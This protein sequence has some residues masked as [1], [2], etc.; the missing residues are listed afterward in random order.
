METGTLARCPTHFPYCLL[1]GAAYASEGGTLSESPG[2]GVGNVWHV[3]YVVGG[4]PIGKTS[5]EDGMAEAPPPA[6]RCADWEVLGGTCYP[7]AVDGPGG[8]SP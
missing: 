6:S 2:G 7:S 1:V 8:Y 5:P 4:I 3:W